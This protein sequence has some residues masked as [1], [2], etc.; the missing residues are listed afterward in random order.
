MTDDR[1]TDRRTD[2]RTDRILIARPRLHSMQRGEYD[3]CYVPRATKTDTDSHVSRTE[4]TP[5]V[6]LIVRAYGRKY[7]ISVSRCGK[8]GV[9]RLQYNNHGDDVTDGYIFNCRSPRSEFRSDELIR[10]IIAIVYTVHLLLRTESVKN[11]I[12]NY[13]DFF[14][15]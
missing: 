8:H 15:R 5:A 14:L 1:R 12:A 2:G 7:Y 13:R 4:K 10:K 3:G 9:R 11:V 6:S